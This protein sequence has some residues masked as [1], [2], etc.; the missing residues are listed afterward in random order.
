[1]ICVMSK[2]GKDTLA[3]IKNLNGCLIR[4]LIR[5]NMYDLLLRP[6]GDDDVEAGTTELVLLLLSLQLGTGDSDRTPAASYITSSS[7][8]E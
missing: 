3:Q 1:M 4:K 2:T 6:G 5:C 7:S 8:E